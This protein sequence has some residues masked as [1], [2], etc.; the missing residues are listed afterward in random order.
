MKKL[1]RIFAPAVFA[2]T[3]AAADASGTASIEIRGH[4]ASVSVA[5]T[6]EELQH[7][8]MGVQAMPENRGMLF[9]FPKSSSWCMWMKNT[10]LPLS[11]AFFDDNFRLISI[12]SMTPWSTEIH[13]ALNPARY[14]LEMNDGWFRARGISP[15]DTLSVTRRP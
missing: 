9:V 2:V 7:G 15:G 1:L 14:A 8:L 4:S 3:A 11:V 6:A 5:E 13:C 10:P 12:A